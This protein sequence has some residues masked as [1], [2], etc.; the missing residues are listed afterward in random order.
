MARTFARVPLVAVGVALVLP[1]V[2]V[3]MVLLSVEARSGASAQAGPGAGPQPPVAAYAQTFSMTIYE[4]GRT[5]RLWLADVDSA[6]Y[7]RQ[8]IEADGQ[9]DSDQIYRYDERTLYTA[10]PD[11]SG[12]LAWS[13]MPGVEPENLQLSVLTTGPGAWAAQYGPG[14]HEIPAAQGS[15]RVTVHSVDEAFDP[16]VF[17]LPPG[18]D[19]KPVEG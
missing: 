14:E 1:L 15:L 6:P 10:E 18:T 7:F 9:V 12:E 2:L 8:T 17:E 19:V 5:V 11:A 13:S 16:T 4:E 3:V